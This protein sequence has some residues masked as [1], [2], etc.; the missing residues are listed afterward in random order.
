MDRIMKPLF[1]DTPEEVETF[2]SGGK[3][4]APVPRSEART[5]PG[6]AA[7][8]M[9]LE[10][11]QFIRMNEALGGGKWQGVHAVT[12]KIMGGIYPLLA[13]TLN[14]IERLVP[15]VANIRAVQEI[16]AQAALRVF[17]I[18]KVQD[19]D[20]FM[21]DADLAI[22][23]GAAAIMG[24]ILSGAPVAVLVR[25][26]DGDQGARDIAFINE[27]IQPLLAAQ[28][29]DPVMI[30]RTIEE[31]KAQLSAKVRT[32]KTAPSYKALVM[33]TGNMAV[34]LTEQLGDQNVVKVTDLRF[35]R[36]LEQAGQL[37]AGL[38]ERIRA[39]FALAQ[40]A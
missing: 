14:V 10:I 26:R 36:F 20:V 34:A 23:R 5:A 1:L 7:L 29:Q 35:R 15:A 6:G 8:T 11:D 21:L 2:V 38:A 17:G 22:D 25:D 4:T 12:E 13:N 37:I 31:A 9:T 3:E 40:S 33:A 39:G 24:R 30:A 28:K 27:H 19:S 16:H 32:A 18:T